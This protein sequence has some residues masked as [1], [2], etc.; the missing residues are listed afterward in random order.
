MAIM[1]TATGTRMH[2]GIAV[3]PEIAD[4][5]AVAPKDARD[6][7]QLFFSE[8]ATLEE[9]MGL[10]RFDGHL[11]SGVQPREDV[12]HGEHGEEEASLPSPFVHAGVQGRDRRVVPTR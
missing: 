11:R 12:H 1:T 8:L 10:I 6:M 3:L 7:S 5:R 9:G 2:T 4:P